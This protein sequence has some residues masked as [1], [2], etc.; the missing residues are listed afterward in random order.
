LVNQAALGR[1]PMLWSVHTLWIPRLLS[2]HGYFIW[3]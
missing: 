2:P 1:L 3:D